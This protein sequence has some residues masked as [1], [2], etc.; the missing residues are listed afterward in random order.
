[1]NSLNAILLNKLQI[2]NSYKPITR[3]EAASILRVHM[4]EVQN[5]VAELQ[6]DGW[7]IISDNRGYWMPRGDEDLPQIIRAA[8]T[9]HRH[10]VSE[11]SDVRRFMQIARNIKRRKQQSLFSV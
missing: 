5:I 1:M 11:L 8:R 6:N 9:R 10:A 3:R 7:Q 2:T 4:R